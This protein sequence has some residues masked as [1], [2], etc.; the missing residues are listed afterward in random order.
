MV[1]WHHRRGRIHR[2][3]RLVFDDG[4]Q[5]RRPDVCIRP[6]RTA[7]LYGGMRLEGLY[8]LLEGAGH[9]PKGA[10]GRRGSGRMGSTGGGSTA[11]KPNSGTDANDR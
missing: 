2:R 3:R 5:R 6:L 9:D 8:R 7:T 1:R 4:R 11:D 10:E